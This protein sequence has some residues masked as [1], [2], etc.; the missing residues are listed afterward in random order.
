MKSPL[1]IATFVAL[2]A[3]LVSLPASAAMWTI[4]LHGGGK[5][6]TRYQPQVASWDANRVVF[7]TEVGN[8]VSVPKG[9]IENI[10][11]DIE[12]RGFGK[13]INTTTVMLGEAPNDLAA[14]QGGGGAGAQAAPAPEEEAPYT[15][16]QFV[17]PSA[18]QGIPGSLIPSGYGGQQQRTPAPAPAPAPAPPPATP[19]TGQ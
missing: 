14:D 13:V 6:Q 8:L 10:S 12:N 5:F 18:A 16:Q 11:S 9:D 15:V 19:P 1:R 4:K 3:L 7:L 17:E 2:A